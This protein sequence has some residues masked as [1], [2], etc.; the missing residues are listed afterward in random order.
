[1][2]AQPS[3]I[4]RAERVT[5]GLEHL[6]QLAGADARTRGVSRFA[7]TSQDMAARRWFQNEAEAGGL[8][9]EI[10]PFGNILAWTEPPVDGC[11]AVAAGSHLDSIPNGGNYDGALGALCA[12]EA[13]RSI[14][15]SGL[16]QRRPLVAIGF[17]A[18]ESIR[19]GIGCL[20]SAALVGTLEPDEL[21]ALTD[22]EGITLRQALL[23]AGLLPENVARARRAP[24]WANAFLEV[25][26]DQGPEL[27]EMG[28]PLGVVTAIAGPV[29]HWVTFLGEAMHSGAAPMRSRHDALAG[30]AEWVVKI[31][32]LGQA[33]APHRVVTTVG[34]VEA[35]P[36]LMTVVPGKARV[37]VD[38]RGPDRT[39]TW[40]VWDMIWTE[41]QE[42][43]RR[44]GLAL[45]KQ[46][47]FELEPVRASTVMIDLLS[48]QCRELRIPFQEMPSGSGHDAMN[49]ARQMDAGMLF[50]R[51]RSGVSHN[52]LEYSAPEDIDAA[53]QVLTR[54]L[55]QL[56]SVV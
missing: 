30:A 33:F 39:Q 8:F 7:F 19:Y 53:L 37:A 52:P 4:A 49:L 20:G 32:S 54:A 2:G 11:P 25:H 26:I 5:N 17:A 34:N 41:A 24:G 29:R 10:D 22:G 38:V 27:N 55:W 56:A 48:N 3:I 50:V 35:H 51:N 47:V 12:L 36:G 15:E 16:R 46:L 6:W 42:I 23:G 44:R 14:H 9:T 18:E 1:V 31:E 13:V 45:S 43:G 21:L 40:A 28:L